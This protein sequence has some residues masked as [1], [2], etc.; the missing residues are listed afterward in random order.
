MWMVSRER[1][2]FLGLAA[3][4]GI[5]EASHRSPVAPTIALRALLAMLHALGG[6]SREPFDE[7]WA[8]A[9]ETTPRSVGHPGGGYMRGCATMRDWHRIARQLGAPGDADYLVAISVASRRNDRDSAAANDQDAAVCNRYRMTASRAEA[10]R[11]YG[12]D[13]EPLGDWDAPPIPDLFP[14]KPAW[15]VRQAD[16]ARVL[17][18]MAWGVPTTV[19]GANGQ[20]IEKPVTN[21][22]NLASLFW[23]SML[24]TPAQRCLVPVTSFSE[25]HHVRDADGKLP[26]HWFDVPS[27]A[28]F[29]F[30]GIWR[31]ST[32]GVTFAFLTCEPNS[33]VGPIHP[34]AMPVILHDEDEQRWLDGADAAELAQPYPAQ[35]M[36]LYR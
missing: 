10:L 2:I 7:F 32:M 20:P 25:Y 35:L 36:A 27:R 17:E 24:A 14:K 28:I 22:R 18:R 33:I 11:R 31:P 6:G 1:T 30:A 13:V 9:T 4:F 19:R 29:S 8:D 12:V 34:K 21:V 15:V 3:L 23:R 16:G 26:L 5:A